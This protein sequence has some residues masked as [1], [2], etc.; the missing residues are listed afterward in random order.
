[1]WMSMVAM[2]SRQQI[3]RSQSIHNSLL[4]IRRLA[5]S[6]MMSET[7]SDAISK[8]TLESLKVCIDVHPENSRGAVITDNKWTPGQTLRVCFLDGDPIVQ[9]KIE[10][11]AHQW[12]QYINIRF[13]FGND[14]D[15]EIRISCQPGG[16]WSYIG[17]GALSIAKDRPTMNYGWLKPDTPDEEYSRVVLHEFGHA[18]GCIHEHQHPEAG[19]PWNRDA[20]YRYYMETNNWTKEDV[21]NNLFAQYSKDV[22]QFSQFDTQSIMLY[23]IPKELTTNGFEVGWN[24]YLSETDKAFMGKIYPGAVQGRT[25]L[26]SGQSLQPGQSLR[27]PNQLHT[28]IMQTDG[29]VVLYDRHSQPLWA[30][31][32]GGSIVPREFIMQTD[33]N[34]VLYGMDNRPNWASNTSG[35][36]GAF[37]DVQDD[38]NLVVYRSG[39]QT[40]TADNAL[41]ASASNDL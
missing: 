37:L 7:I 13:E 23:P 14:P 36:S 3:F 6:E 16:S 21:D 20:V 32:T 25:T 8:N 34:L 38:G 18:L 19:I 2:M 9:Q 33:G 22:T 27:S 17:T 1:M 12:S 28:L 29:N 11:V 39:S 5:M 40:Q 41:W 24:K 4:T 35:N 30:T 10:A 15:A 26:A 31:N